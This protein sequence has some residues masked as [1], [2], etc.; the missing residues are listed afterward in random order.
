MRALKGRVWGRMA[1]ANGVGVVGTGEAVEIF[2]VATGAVIKSFQSKGGTVAS[3]ITISR[4][5]VAFGE[6]FSWSS[7]NR[8]GSTLT[9]LGIK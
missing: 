8:A 3:T 1:F 6:G 9:V 2:D 4:G 5:R 7:G